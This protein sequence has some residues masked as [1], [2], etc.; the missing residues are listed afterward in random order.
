MPKI[1]RTDKWG[2]LP[3]KYQLP[4]LEETVSIYRDMVRRLISIVNLRWKEIAIVEAQQRYVEQLFHQTSYNPN[5]KFARF[6]GLGTKLYKFPSYLRRAAINDAIGHVSSFHSRYYDWQGGTRKRRTAKPPGL[7][8]SCGV[9]PDLYKNQC[10]KIAANY[11]SAEIKVYKDKDWVWESIQIGSIARRHLIPGVKQLS[12]TLVVKNGAASLS[13]PYW[14]PSLKSSQTDRYCGVDLGINTTAVCSIV[15]ESGVVYARKFIHDGIALD[16][17]DKHLARISRRARLTK[18]LHKGFAKVHYRKAANISKNIANQTAKQ[19]INFAIANNATTVV[20]ENL[21]NWKP[22]GGKRKS[23]LKQ[24]FHGWV[25]SAIVD[26]L[27]QLGQEYGIKIVSVYA[28]GTSSF[29]YDGTGKVK[30]DQDNYALGSFSTKKRY[31]IDLSASYNIAAR[32]IA[33]KLKL[34]TKHGK[35]LASQ[36]SGS[37]PRSWVSL[38]SLWSNPAM[39]I[40][41]IPRLQPQRV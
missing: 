36:N 4:I 37:K 32:H 34:A 41:Q 27:E 22:K 3:D 23:S 30:R 24:R 13:V 20:S 28:R 1:I 40:D 31:S 14:I 8:T 16:K 11:Q 21:R 18:K 2:L 19:I 7:N 9:Y 6:F 17:R 38:S 15:N 35:L 29:A 33:H 5:P 10:I 12:P 39:M 25:K 26:R